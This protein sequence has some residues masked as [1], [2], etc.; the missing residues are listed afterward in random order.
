MKK[1]IWILIFFFIGIALPCFGEQG[2]LPDK[3]Y[4]VINDKI[5]VGYAHYDE[6]DGVVVFWVMNRGKWFYDLKDASYGVVMNEN[7][8]ERGYGLVVKDKVNLGYN[9]D[10]LILNPFLSDGIDKGILIRCYSP[11]GILPSADVKGY[12]IRL[13][14]GRKI[15]FGYEILT[16]EQKTMRHIKRLWTDFINNR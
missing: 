12:L 9:A 8:K 10:S 11:V 5:F 7:K 3:H 15:R 6:H 14:G 13:K 4:F 2:I 16:W 1:I